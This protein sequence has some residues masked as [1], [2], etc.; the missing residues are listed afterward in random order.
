MAELPYR[1]SDRER[2]NLQNVVDYTHISSLPEIWSIAADRFGDI[3]ALHDPHSKPEVKITYTELYSQMRGFAAGLQALG[4][5]PESKVSLF[6]E[7]SPRWF[8]ADQGIMMAG[9]VNA[10]R[11]SDADKDELLYI[12]EN[13]DSNTLVVENLKT[14]QKLRSDLESLPVHLVVLLSDENPPEDNLHIVNFEQLIASG[15]DYDLQPAQ[16]DSDTLATLL[17][18]SGTTGKP[19]GVMLTHGNLLHQVRT[20]GTIIIPEKRDR[21]LSLLP[22]W[23]AYERA[24]EYFLLSQGC[25]QIYTNRR[26]FKKDLEEYSPHYMIAVPRVWEAIYD[27]AQKKFRE[28]S[29]TQQSLVYQFLDISKRYMRAKK[30][31][32][33]LS[34]EKPNPSGSE[35]LAAKVK[36]SS[37]YP[38]HALADRIVYSKVRDA[39]GGQI[40]T[41]ISG[42]GSLSEEIDLFY[43]I[44]GIELIVGYG[45]T[46]TSPVTNARR[47]WRNVI[48][49]S[50]QPIAGTENRIVNPETRQDV[51]QG[52]KGLVL[53][54][55]PQVM[56]GYYKKPEATEKAIDIDG[57]FDTGDLGFL[58]IDNDLVITG[59][60]KDT[61]VLSNGEN[62]E[63]QPLENACIRSK[64]INQIVVVGQD[65]RSLGAL[66]VPDMECLEQWIKENKVDV[67]LEDAEALNNSKPVRDL[68]RQE[69][70]REVKDR[71]GY[72]SDDRITAFELIVEPFSIENGMM[73][74]TMKI[75]RNVVADHY[76]DVIDQMYEK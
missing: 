62:I 33:G 13:S 21:V 76:Q 56:K 22:S 16:Q 40:K 3:L 34:L 61:I 45:L 49:A 53:V 39:V 10:V 54:R 24:A 15:K 20:L 70:D 42:G 12:Y 23:H 68:F 19:K 18:T 63:P 74:Q 4:V 52:E 69:L 27:S 75:K 14:F 37:L 35:R 59:R 73:T 2:E 50:G 58:T 51:P 43:A 64:Y 11:S 41:I 60:A 28:Q 5:K 44:A 30:V 55:G 17:Y 66:I 26:Y 65:R 67:S 9:A 71:P 38:L 6:S 72:R 36:A 31:S 48:G 57:W 32:E 29:K 46:E 1:M 25:T 47:P 8:I 7:N